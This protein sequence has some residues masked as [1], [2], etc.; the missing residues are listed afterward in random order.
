MNRPSMSCWLGLAEGFV[1]P[2]KS[3]GG[4]G[5]FGRWEKGFQPHQRGSGIVGEP[6]RGVT[7]SA[8]RSPSYEAQK[9]FLAPL[10]AGPGSPARVSARWSG[11]DPFRPRSAPAGRARG[12]PSPYEGPERI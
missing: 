2:N 9:G 6:R 3:P 4:Q 10:L 8:C 1:G 12:A 7:L 11:G 5:R